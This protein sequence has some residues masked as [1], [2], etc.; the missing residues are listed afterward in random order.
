LVTREG[1]E[2]LHAGRGKID[3][4]VESDLFEFTGGELLA[5][6][7]LIGLAFASEFQNLAA[8]HEADWAHVGFFVD[9]D[10]VVAVA[11]GC[12]AFTAADFQVFDFV[13]GDMMFVW[14]FHFENERGLSSAA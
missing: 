1:E 9:L 10:A 2:L 14:V 11:A 13:F 6:L 12:A 4:V 8:G 5:E 7:P 3:F